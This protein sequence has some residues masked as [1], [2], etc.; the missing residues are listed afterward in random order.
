MNELL[1]KVTR[2]T[3]FIIESNYI[4]RG[5]VL[6]E[7]E[8]IS[9]IPVSLRSKRKKTGRK[10]ARRSSLFKNLS[11]WY[12]V[13]AHHRLSWNRI[14]ER[15]SSRKSYSLW[16]PLPSVRRGIGTTPTRSR[17]YREDHR[18]HG[19]DSGHQNPSPHRQSHC[20][21]RF[22]DSDCGRNKRP[23]WCA[24]ASPFGLVELKSHTDGNGWV[25]E[26]APWQGKKDAEAIGEGELK[27]ILDDADSDGPLVNYKE[28]GEQG[29][30][31][32][33]SM[34][35]RNRLAPTQ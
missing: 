30:V 9:L 1:A 14:K 33:A 32:R 4:Q 5:N 13:L 3:Q 24:A 15:K 18:R 8:N 25:E 34:K 17:Q 26:L 11:R 27:S 10:L 21:R 23:T 7:G 28:K 22:R 2:R 35:W 20:R 16:S 29:R 19:K 31:C 6:A 12:S